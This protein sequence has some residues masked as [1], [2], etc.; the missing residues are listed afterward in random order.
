VQVINLG[1]EPWEALEMDLPVEDV[2]Y[3]RRQAVASYVEAYGAARGEDWAEWLQ[4]HRVELNALS[5]EAFLEWLDGKLAAFDTGKVIP[6]ATVLEARYTVALRTALEEK[7]TEQILAD[8]DLDG[9]VE[10]AYS[11]LAETTVRD[12]IE[13]PARVAECLSTTPTDRWSIPVEKL[14]HRRAHAAEGEADDAHGG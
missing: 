4:T 11:A 3:E 6:P 2:T 10:A 12:T 1:L 7:L 14:A 13:L 8:A 5:T 9:Q